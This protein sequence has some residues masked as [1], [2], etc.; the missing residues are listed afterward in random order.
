MIY[1][2]NKGKISLN[3]TI[4]LLGTSFLKIRK[5]YINPENVGE[6]ILKEN[7][8]DKRRGSCKVTVTAFCKK[9][10]AVTVRW[11]NKADATEKFYK[12]V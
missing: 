9:P 1:G 4:T 6:I 2:Y 10:S 12:T 8:F 3:R 7:P 5:L 11:I